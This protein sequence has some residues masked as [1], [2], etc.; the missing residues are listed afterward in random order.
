MPAKRPTK[1]DDNT[2]IVRAVERVT[3]SEPVRGED[4]LPARLAKELTAAK[5]RIASKPR[6]S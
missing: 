3:D 4:L 2:Q 1:P 5:A 6:R